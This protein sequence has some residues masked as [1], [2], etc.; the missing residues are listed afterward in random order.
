[1]G[2]NT[3]S[4]IQAAKAL[5]DKMQSHVLEAALDWGQAI[6]EAEL[7]VDEKLKTLADSKAR[8]AGC[9]LMR[10]STGIAKIL[11]PRRER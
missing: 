11:R 1:M 5:V 8:L 9:E 10:L 3:E 4:Q 2:T 6:N 7:E